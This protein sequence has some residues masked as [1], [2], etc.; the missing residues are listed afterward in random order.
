M[1]ESRPRRE[2]AELVLKYQQ[3]TP[4]EVNSYNEENTKNVFIQP[5]FE[6]LGWDFHDIH[7]VTAEH[8]TGSRRR[9]DYAFRINGVSRFYVEAKPL[10]DTLDAHPEWLRRAVSY[11][12]N[13]GIPWVVLTNFK[14]LWLLPG[15]VEDPQP[16]SFVRIR[17]DD[18]HSDFERL[19]W[20]SKDSVTSGRLET[21]AAK[22]NLLPTRIPIEQRLYDQLR[23]WRERLFNDIHTYNPQIPFETVD[24]VIQKLLNRLI[25]IRTCED[26]LIED[27]KLLSLARQSQA[28]QLRW[29]LLAELRSVFAEYDRDYDSDLFTMHLLD[30]PPDRIR[31]DPETLQDVVFGLYEVPGGLAE[32]DFAEIDADILGAVYEQ[33]LG[34]I[35]QAARDRARQTP[36]IRLDLGMAQ[37]IT[38]ELAAPKR[39]R[40]EQGIYYTPSWV[41]DY[42]VGETVGRFIDEHH[43]APEAIHEVRILDMSCGSGSFLIRA[44]DELL[45]WHATAHDRDE[46]AIDPAERTVILRNGIYGV[47]L[48]QQAVEISRLN[49]LLRSL[50]ARG[51]LPSLTENI[52]RDNALIDGSEEDLLPFFGDA[53]EGRRPF[54]WEYEFKDAMD[55]SGF[56]IIIG[57]PPYVRIQS[58][59]RAEANYYRKSYESAYGSFDLYVLFMER[60]LQLLKP[61]GRLGFITSGKFLKSS[62]GKKLQELLLR[63]ATVERILDLSDLQVFEDATTYPMVMVFRKGS[64]GAS[65]FDYVAVSSGVGGGVDTPD[66]T[67]ATITLAAQDVLDT[68]IWPPLS[69]DERHIAKKLLDMSH[70]LGDISTNIFT[71]LQTSADSVYHLEQLARTSDETVK[72]HSR[73]LDSEVELET[74]ILKPLLSGKHVDRF[75]VQPDRQLLLFPYRVVDETAELIPANEFAE[76]YPLCWD[77]LE[78]NREPLEGRERGK[79]RH[80][81]WYAYGRHQSLALHDRRKLAIPRLVGRLEVF[82]D[83][84]GRYYLDNVDVGGVLLKDTSE[85]SYLYVSGVLNSTLINWYFQRLSAPFRGGYRT[86]NRQFI[87]PLPIHVI[88]TSSERQLHDAIVTKV[89]RMMELHD[90]LDSLKGLVTSERDDLM[91]EIDRV[92]SDIDDLVYELYGLTAS[93]RRLT[94]SGG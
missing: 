26:R 16:R 4:L 29:G 69:V 86:A 20:L 71:G 46:S 74:A 84:E 19:M 73:S 34:H 1:S 18:F 81:K 21:E 2:I 56:D 94:V 22:F 55:S 35:A 15:D 70:T 47:D 77:Y 45:R 33:Y 78:S 72:A 48:D 65:E 24:E 41:V 12:Y 88:E 76:R 5:L 51:L 54:D 91:R 28:N 43:Q 42:I 61:G 44:Y 89:R 50:A 82:F 7:E 3:L 92:D 32:Y 52:K 13:K 63:E 58:Q 93:E 67:K 90:R 49:L 68:G 6:A 85:E 62:Y 39:R 10:R 17:A 8:P 80:D 40:K 11:A 25:F 66:L 60:A 57:N 23:Q 9:V 37:D 31:M 38:V 27:R 79:M 59:D 83:S 53:W 87:Q 30:T 36:Q 64:D 14:D 75:A